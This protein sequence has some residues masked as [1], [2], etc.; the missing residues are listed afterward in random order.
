MKALHRS[1][2]TPDTRHRVVLNERDEAVGLGQCP[3][4]RSSASVNSATAASDRPARMRTIQD[5]RG[6]PELVDVP[7][8]VPGGELQQAFTLVGRALCRS[9]QVQRQT[10]QCEGRHLAG[11]TAQRQERGV[12]EVSLHRLGV[13]RP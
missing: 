9:A 11:V 7:G 5:V 2:P 10:R 4:A 6:F 1:A 3:L 13:D 8:E 12:F